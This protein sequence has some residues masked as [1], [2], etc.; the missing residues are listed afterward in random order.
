MVD[1][2]VYMSATIAVISTEKVKLYKYT[3]KINVNKIAGLTRLI[4]YNV[5]SHD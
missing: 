4:N 1:T 2:L 3:P 5:P